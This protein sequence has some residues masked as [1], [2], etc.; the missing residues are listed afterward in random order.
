MKFK[1]KKSYYRA[2]SII[3]SLLMVLLSLPISYV[4][5]NEEETPEEPTQDITET[6]ELIETLK[7]R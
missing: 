1:I 6:E 5:A 3:I 4:Y 2:I 7:F